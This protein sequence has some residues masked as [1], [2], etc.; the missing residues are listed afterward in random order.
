[1]LQGLGLDGK[2]RDYI[3]KA[4]KELQAAVNREK[5]QQE[6]MSKKSW[7]LE[8]TEMSVNVRD[9]GSICPTQCDW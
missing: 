5:K 7:N 9:I 2:E 8:E 3:K 6:K 1:M 4:T